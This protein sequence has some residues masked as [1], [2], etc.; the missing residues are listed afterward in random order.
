MTTNDRYIGKTLGCYVV[1]DKTAQ[2]DSSRHL[3]YKCECTFCGTVEIISPRALGSTK[4]CIHFDSL[5]FP[6]LY[7]MPIHDSGLKSVFSGMKHRCYDKK[8]KDYRF[9]G[10]KGIRV[11][12]DWLYNPV[13]FILWAHKNGYKENLTIDRID[14]SKDYCPE[15]CRWITREENSRRAGKVNF[16]TIGDKTLSG[17]QWAKEIHKATNFVNGYIRKYGKEKTI[18]MLKSYLNC[19]QD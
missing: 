1:L 14:S 11:C 10:A 18:E 19:E 12:S 8:D 7:K 5:G 15:N 9:Y 4:K 2:R 17:R 6:A 16:I 3:Q 13:E